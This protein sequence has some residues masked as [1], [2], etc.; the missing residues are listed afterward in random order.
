MSIAILFALLSLQNLLPWSLG[1]PGMPW[2][3]ALHTAV[4]FTT[5]T[6]WQNYAGESTTGHLA[7]MAGLGV[8]AFASGS[9]GIC[10]ALALVRGL[11]RHGGHE[12]GNFW[13]DL[14]R[15]IFRIFL[16]LAI[17]AGLVL[18]ALGVQQNLAGARDD[19]HRGRRNPDHHR[20]PRRLLG[21]DQVDDR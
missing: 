1:H 7:V 11:V 21:A 15:S 4:S 9:V 16:P 17:V 6:S 10:A 3:Q 5:N 19:H 18:V 2:Q 13:V 12:L 8:Q 20:R 14:F